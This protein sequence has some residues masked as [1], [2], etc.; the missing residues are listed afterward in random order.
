MMTDKYTNILVAVD[1]SAQAEKAFEEAIA[2]SKRNDAVLCILSTFAIPTYGSIGLSIQGV[3]DVAEKE[4]E[5]LVQEKTEQAKNLGLKNVI[6]RV[7]QGNPKHVIVKMVKNEGYD[8]VIMGASGK[9][10]IER[11]LL[12]SNTSFVVTHAPC[13]VLVVK[14]EN[15]AD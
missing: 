5:K 11:T 15:Q 13:D 9:G 8:L 2:I 6:Y 3:I 7:V 10:A 14:D 12:G 4:T 1:D